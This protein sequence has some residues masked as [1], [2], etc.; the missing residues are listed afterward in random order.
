MLPLE[1][2]LHPTMEQFAGANVYGRP[3]MHRAAD[4]EVRF[5][6]CEG[7]G[8]RELGVEPGGATG[9]HVGD[10]YKDP[11]IA[12]HLQRA[13]A[14]ETF[15]AELTLG[16][17]V[18]DAWYSPLRD[19]TGNITGVIGV[20]VD[21]TER[22]RLSSRLLEAEKMEAIGRLAAGVAH[23]FNNQL[24]AILGFAQMLQLSF[25]ADDP[26]GDDIQQILKGE[27]RATTPC[28]KSPT[29]VVASIPRPRRT[30]SN[31]STPRKNR[32]KAPA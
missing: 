28:W 20:A 25:A 17:P 12:R 3:V 29:A 21:I 18:F 13:L 26:R 16:G 22:V 23:D 31:R 30:S 1:R 15:Q 7:H 8:L 10:L 24:T 32:A 11:R 5:T 9:R 27:H 4:R 19:A 6:L 14:G 2:C